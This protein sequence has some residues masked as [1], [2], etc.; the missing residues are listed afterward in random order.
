MSIQNGNFAPFNQCMTKAGLT[1]G[2]TTTYSITA[3]PLY[4][5]VNGKWYSKATVTNGATPTTDANSGSAYTAIPVNGIGVFVFGYDSSGNIKVA[6]GGIESLDVSG[7]PLKA[8]LFPAVADGVT[9]F[10]YL[11]T[12]V[13]STGSAWTMGSSNLA[14]PPTGVTHTFVDV[15]VLPDRP[16][17]S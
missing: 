16:Q 5:T 9:P 17:V 14:G 13:G 1:A 8:P 4:F 10:G 11:V 15:N 6:Q 3:N 2:T 12:K 7:N